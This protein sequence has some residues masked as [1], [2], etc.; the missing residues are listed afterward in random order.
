MYF[1]NETDENPATFE[2]KLARLPTSLSESLEAL[3]KDNVLR[4]MIGEKLFVAIKGVRK[5]SSLKGY[6]REIQFMNLC[7]ASSIFPP[8]WINHANHE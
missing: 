4:E 1:T 3:E 6:L 2:G 5:V 8:Q 7:M